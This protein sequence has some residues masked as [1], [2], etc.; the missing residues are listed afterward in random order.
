LAAGAGSSSA[1]PP[2]RAVSHCTAGETALYSCRFGRKHGSVCVAPGRVAYRFGPL[3]KPEIEI[4]S[5]P[6]WS[7]VRIGGVVGGGGGYQKHLRFTADG[8]DYV[9]YDGIAGRYT[10][11][12]GKRWHGIIVQQGD[13]ELANLACRRATVLSERGVDEASDWAP[14]A[15]K[16]TLA[17]DDG[18]FEA[19]F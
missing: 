16:E 5:A 4:A 8:Y 10:E 3:G 13:S 7:N 11:A 19:W 12:P 6:D 17:D 2:R 14:E 9:V 1:Q 18:R 15:V